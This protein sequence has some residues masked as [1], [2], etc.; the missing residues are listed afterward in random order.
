MKLNLACG[1]RR[2][3]GYLGVDI[4]AGEAVDVVHDLLDFPWPWEDSSVEAAYC[5]HFV[6]HIGHEDGR[7]LI[8]FMNEVWRVLEPGGLIE[9][10]HPYGHSNRAFQ[11]PT[12]KRYIVAETW[13]YFSQDWLKANQLDHYPIR[14]DFEQVAVVGHFSSP[15]DLRSDESRQFGV[16]HYVNVLADLQITLRA[17]KA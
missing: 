1:Q 5:S 4:V 17:R 3:D 12:H 7:D 15:W 14:C 8:A 9:I 10:W 16:Q 11:D 13:T 6:E 2:I